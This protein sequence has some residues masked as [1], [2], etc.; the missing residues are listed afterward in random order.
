MLV[1]LLNS[2]HLLILEI[3]TTTLW[4]RHDICPNFTDEE[5]KT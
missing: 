1:I 5:T 2:L 3:S 4:G